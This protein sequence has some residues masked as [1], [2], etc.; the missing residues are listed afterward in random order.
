MRM[1]GK[2]GRA[3]TDGDKRFL[4]DNASMHVMKHLSAERAAHE[5]PRFRH[6]CTAKRKTSGRTLP[7]CVQVSLQGGFLETQ[8]LKTPEN[9]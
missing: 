5:H 6:R 3:R 2:E 7:P 4:S 9:S 8:R 1:R